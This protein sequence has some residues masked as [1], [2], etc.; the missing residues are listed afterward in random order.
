MNI[1]RLIF[2]VALSFSL[3]VNIPRLV[4]L[5]GNEGSLVSSF[6]GISI[7]DTV[8]RMVSLFGFCYL[9]LKFNIEWN[10]TWFKKKAFFKSSIL[11][12]IMLFLWMVL[13]RIFDVAVN[14]GDST[15]LTPRFNWF[16]Y[17]FIMIMLL[18]ISKTIALN[19]RA[20]T[21]AIEKEI[22]KQQSLKNELAALKNQV[23]P[24]FLF[25][26][27]NSLSLLVRE[28][29]KAAGKFI[30][31]LSFLYRYILQSK[32]HDMVTL[33]EEMRF[34]ESYIYLIQQRYQASFQIEINISEDLF[35]HKIPT[36]SLQLLVEN[37]IKHNEISASRPF[38]VKIFNEDGWIIVK[39]KIQRRTSHVESTN[40]G[41]SN[42]NTR[43]A[44]LIG[45]EVLIKD[46]NGYF[47]VKLPLT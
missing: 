36:L 29:Q 35:Q 6:L 12:F 18:V 14:S 19:N 5:F 23:N 40:V 26:S 8:F 16:V 4:F 22:L 31:K 47:I 39:N 32:N 7:K 15:T 17:F 41:L 1:N 45:Q 43:F 3:L 24:H 33:K 21:D 38:V 30:N 10:I 46:I 44:L 34:L 28:D 37:A 25:N 11:S 13:F 9:M 20:K 27:L 2:I 42:L